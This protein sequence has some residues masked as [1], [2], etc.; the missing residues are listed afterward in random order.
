MLCLIFPDRLPFEHV[1]LVRQLFISGSLALAHIGPL[2]DPTSDQAYKERVRAEMD[3]LRALLE[4]IEA[5]S[6]AIANE[7]LALQH[8]QVD[9]FVPK[10]DDD[11][12]TKRRKAAEM[13]DFHVRVQETVERIQRAQSAV[14][15]TSIAPGVLPVPEAHSRTDTGP[16]EKADLGGGEDAPSA[17]HG[18]KPESGAAGDAVEHV[19]GSS[20]EVPPPLD[21]TQ[22]AHERPVSILVAPL[23]ATSTP[24]QPP[25]ELPRPAPGERDKVDK[26]QPDAGA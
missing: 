16:P 23:D 21:E 4:R 5:S 14:P 25:E 6:E 1:T 10:T 9:P 12:R 3:E 8:V 24:S 2:L 7:A 13:A 22:P 18:A 15:T 11:E 20:A 17:A 26:E 19:V